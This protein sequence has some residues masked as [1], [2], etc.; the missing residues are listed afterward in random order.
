MKKIYQKGQGIKCQPAYSGI[1]LF[2]MKFL[3]QWYDLSDIGTEELVKKFLNYIRFYGFR[4]EDQIP[5]HTTL[6]GFHN[7]I[8]PKKVYETLLKKINKEL[9]K[10]Q[11]IVK[12]GV[13]V[14]ASITVSPFFLKGAPTYVVEDRKE[15]GK[16]QISQRKERVKKET[17]S[18]VDIQGKYLKKSGKLYYGYKKHI[19]SG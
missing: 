18:G 4:L 1:S 19:G 15:D 6:C 7:E 8:V 5:D 13:I 16:K 14:E 17:Q 9:E 3:S 2:K 10:Y 12:T 11:E